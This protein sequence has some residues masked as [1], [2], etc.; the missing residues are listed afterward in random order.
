MSTYVERA[1]R[2]SLVRTWMVSVAL[3]LLVSLSVGACG[4]SDHGAGV[5]A[6]SAPAAEDIDMKPTDFHNLR[7]MTHVRGFYIDNRLGHL[8]DALRVANSP[9]GGV[10]P[11]GTIVQL[12]PQEAMV[13]RRKG[14]NAA[15]NDWEFFFLATSKDGTQIIT[16]GA[17]DTVNRFGA[18]C[19]SC[20]AAAD[21]KW[22]FICEQN[23]GCAPLPFGHDVFEAIQRADPRPG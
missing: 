20:H 6:T 10:Y 22:D 17:K 15:T 19:F 23:H 5:A 18:N 14:W 3:A 4:K 11:V 2:G 13:K 9:D 7:T 1:V 21:P 16:R 8:A 12:V